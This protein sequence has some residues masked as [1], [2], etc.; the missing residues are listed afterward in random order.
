MLGS[1]RACGGQRG[2]MSRDTMPRLQRYT[3]TST[4]A[5]SPKSTRASPTWRA[6]WLQRASLTASSILDRD[7]PRHPRLLHRHARELVHR[8]HRGLVVRMM[9]LHA[10]RHVFHNLGETAYVRVVGGASTS[11]SRQNGAGSA[12]RSRTPGNSR[13]RFLAAD[14]KWIV[15]FFLRRSR[16]DRQP[17]DSTSSPSISM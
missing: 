5:P 10:L 17:A 1:V 2:S 3:P 11:S 4:G 13:Q 9:R 14:S 12:R 6:L 7:H 16:H 8:L 15:L